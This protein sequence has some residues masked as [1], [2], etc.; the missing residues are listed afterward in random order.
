[1]DLDILGR[2][3]DKNDEGYAVFQT[4]SFLWWTVFPFHR[5]EME[6]LCGHFN[7]I[8]GLIHLKSLGWGGGFARLAIPLS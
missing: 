3:E 2:R 6:T 7:L 8:I 5:P 1:M 4:F